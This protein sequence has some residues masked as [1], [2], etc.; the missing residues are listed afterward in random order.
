MQPPP[1]ADRPPQFSLRYLLLELLW[2]GVAL[3]SFKM[4]WNLDGAPAFVAFA[5]GY[6]SL[7][8]AI[9]GLFLHMKAGAGMS[10]LMVALPAGYVL[11]LALFFSALAVVFYLL[12]LMLEA[13][14]RAFLM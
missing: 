4:A 2:I 1:S 12:G 3:G 14:I 5:L 11:A 10:V 9:G 7:A 13:L 6:F 8:A